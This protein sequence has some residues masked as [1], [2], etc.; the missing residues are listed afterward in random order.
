MMFSIP[1]YK[2]RSCIYFLLLFCRFSAEGRLSNWIF[3]ILMA[4]FRYPGL[5]GDTPFS[6]KLM[7]CHWP[8]NNFNVDFIDVLK[9]NCCHRA[10][11]LASTG[12]SPPHVALKPM[13]EIGI[14]NKLTSE[15][16]ITLP[17]SVA[18]MDNTRP[19]KA[20]EPLFRMKYFVF[21]GLNSVKIKVFCWS[22][23][24]LITW[25]KVFVLVIMPVC[26]FWI[27]SSWLF[28]CAC[29]FS[30]SSILLLCSSCY[31]SKLLSGLPSSM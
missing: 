14:L 20:T 28:S 5:F 21:A 31:F 4:N 18:S 17:F 16:W 7:S 23:T 11:S 26:C 2:R 13:F 9:S 19:A 30:I 25:V 8:G 1:W 6:V 29:C 3:S 10:N 24:D 27:V 22:L 15:I 12:F